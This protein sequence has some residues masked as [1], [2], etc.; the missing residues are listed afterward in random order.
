MD[1]RRPRRLLLLLLACLLGGL[2]VGA[3]G[4]GI[5]GDGSWFLALPL[6]LAAGWWAVADPSA[7]L[8]PDE[9]SERPRR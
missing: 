3:V 9:P 6:A 2:L 8:P 7:C 4:H 1:P 5:T